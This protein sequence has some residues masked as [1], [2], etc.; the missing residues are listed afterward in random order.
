MHSEY[1]E[2]YV[3]ELKMKIVSISTCYKNYYTFV[4]LFLSNARIP[5]SICFVCT[6]QNTQACLFASGPS[7]P[8]KK[9]KLSTLFHPKNKYTRMMSWTF[10]VCLK[11]HVH[12][13]RLNIA[14][15]FTILLL[16]NT[17]NKSKKQQMLHKKRDEQKER[18]SGCFQFG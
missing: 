17:K 13:K 15:I 16:N 6:H 14:R 5:I 9:Q 18:F 7:I 11:T 12:I 1:D 4:T 8:K 10:F 3:V 2:E